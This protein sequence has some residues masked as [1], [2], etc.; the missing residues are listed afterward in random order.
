VEVDRFRRAL[1]R[2]PRLALRLFTEAERAYGSSFADPAPRLAARFAAKEATMK[3]L[4]VGLGAF[5]FQEVEVV[6]RPSGAP[7]LRITGSAAALA[8]ER[9]ITA[10]HL[11]I[12]HTD[13]S[14]EAVV[15]AL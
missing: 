6:R 1:Q 12:T 15:A 7:E 5:S 14:A 11:S 4:G 10:L 8:D 2:R 13:R 3:A 9:G